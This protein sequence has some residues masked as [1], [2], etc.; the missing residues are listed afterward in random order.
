[1]KRMKPYVLGLLLSVLAIVALV[2]CGNDKETSNTNTNTQTNVGT[3]TEAVIET[4]TETETQIVVGTADGVDSSDNVPSTS[5]GNEVYGEWVGTVLVVGKAGYETVGYSETYAESYAQI[6]ND[7]ADG[8]EGYSTVYSI[9]IPKS[10]G[11]CY[12]DAYESVVHKTN[13][14]TSIDNVLAKMNS[15]VVTV[16][17][18]DTMR[19][20]RDEYLYFRTDHHWTQ[21]GAYYAY[22]DFCQAKGISSHNLSEYEQHVFDGFVGTLYTYS[23]HYEPFNQYPDTVYAYE[24]IA[25]ATM[26][27]NSGGSSYEYPI[28]SDVSN[29]SAGNKYAGCFIGGDSALCVIKNNDLSDG[30][31]CILVKESFG[32]AFAPFLVDHYETVYV[33][34]A[35]YWSGNLI[36]FAKENEVDDVI[37][38]NN[39]L[40]VFT[41]ARQD[42]LKSIVY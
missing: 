21:L 18:Y 20:H 3:E 42:E 7:I 11:I 30:S 38:L 9:P 37:L 24:P 1:M 12:D 28:I 15:N 39:L 27:I 23:N 6:I 36:S 8:L 10:S 17:V 25:N 14:G 40:A 16:D 41:G 13:Q 33:I 35:R 32:N 2:A 22:T 34:D 19:A 4:E 26:T 31:S 5:A 29:S